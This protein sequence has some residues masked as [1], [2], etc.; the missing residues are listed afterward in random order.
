MSFYEEFYSPNNAVLVLSG[1]ITF[2]KAKEL[3]KKYYGNI[4]SSKKKRLKSTRTNIKTSTSVE[5][6]NKN[7]KQQI[8]KRIYRAKSYN[9]SVLES[10]ALDL[11]M[12]ILAGTQVFS[13]K[14]L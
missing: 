11:G 14:S 4:E 3:V 10:L 7:V 1:D 9:D 2:S 13:M 5:L 6:K 12:K 8:W